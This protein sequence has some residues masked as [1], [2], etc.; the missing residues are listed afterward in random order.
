MRPLRNLLACCFLATLMACASV[1]FKPGETTIADVEK[2][3]GRPDRTMPLA[4]GGKEYYWVV[5]R[6][7]TINGGPGEASFKPVVTW[8]VLVFDA[9]GRLKRE[10][11]KSE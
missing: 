6:H 10:S 5:D 1:A 2:Q 11:T 3:W 7:T 4:D 9:D 8:R